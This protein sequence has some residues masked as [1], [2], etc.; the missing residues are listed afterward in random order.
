MQGDEQQD[1]RNRG[2]Q[3]KPDED[4]QGQ[5]ADAPRTDQRDKG[6]QDRGVERGDGNYEDPEQEDQARQRSQESRDSTL[7]EG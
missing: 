6:T 4:E 3:P 5:K 2:G 7:D 1:E